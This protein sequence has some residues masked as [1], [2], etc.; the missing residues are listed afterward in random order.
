MRRGSRAGGKLVEQWFADTPIPAAVAALAGQ[1]ARASLPIVLPFDDMHHLP[2]TTAEQ[3]LGPLLLPGL[4][5]SISRW[6]A[7]PGRRCRLPVALPRRASGI[8]GGCL[9]FGEHEI[10][11]LFPILRRRSG[12]YWPAD[13]RMAVALQAG[14]TLAYRK[15][16]RVSL[17]AGF[18]GHTA[19]V[20][21]YLTEQVLSDLPPTA[22]RT[23]ETDRTA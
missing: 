19:E 5:W 11:A 2:R 23:L 12:I 6:Q 10:D 16:E 8:R 4:P 15:A 20:A 13:A 1:L 22:Q 18:S 21:E 14:T 7:G 9:R 17:I 3:V